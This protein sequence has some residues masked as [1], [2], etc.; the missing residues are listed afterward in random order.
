MAR[1]SHF[2]L[3]LS[4]ADL[5]SMRPYHIR[6]MCR[7]AVKTPH[8]GSVKTC[9]GWRVNWSSRCNTRNHRCFVN[10]S[11]IHCLNQ[12][13]DSNQFLLCKIGFNSLHGCPTVFDHSGAVLAAL[14]VS[15]LTLYGKWLVVLSWRFLTIGAKFY[16]EVVKRY[17]YLIAVTLLRS[18]VNLLGL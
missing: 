13:E 12:G 15:D 17:F 18:I 5:L 1:W 6:I 7:F 16:L 3:A 11:T 10:Y 2:I 8:F 14:T 9:F 4:R